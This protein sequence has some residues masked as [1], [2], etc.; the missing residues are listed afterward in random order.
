M[1]DRV[2][3]EAENSVSPIMTLNLG[4]ASLRVMKPFRR[5]SSGDRF[6]SYDDVLD[7]AGET[8]R[9]QTRTLLRRI[10]LLKDDGTERLCVLKIYRYPNVTGART[11]GLRSKAQREFDA[12]AFCSAMNAPAIVPVACGTR[13]NPAGFVVSCFVITEY[14]EGYVTL[15]DWLTENRPLSSEHADFLSRLLRECGS[16]LRMVHNAR[17]FLFTFS[18]KNILMRPDDLSTVDW[19]FL[20]L[21]YALTLQL[22]PL[23]R[24]GQQRDLGVLAGPILQFAGEDAFE[25]FYGTYLPDP[26]GNSEVSLRNRV[27]KGV[28]SYKKKTPMTRAVK[29]MKRAISATLS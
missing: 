6:T 29:K 22:R 1:G 21:P 13:R 11:I 20:D 5:D 23:A 15:W 16:V 10:S 25:A 26:L 19:R 12:L 9:E 17:L 14:V 27:R 2:T 3:I 24:W 7:L 28:L 4:G 8:L 18:A